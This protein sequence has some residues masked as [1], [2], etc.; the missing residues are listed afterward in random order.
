MCLCVRGWVGGRGLILDEIL[1]TGQQSIFP[2]F[3]S[4]ILSLRVSRGAWIKWLEQCVGTPAT[5]VRSLAGMASKILDVY[6]QCCEH[7]CDK[8][9]RSPFNK[10][11]NFLFFSLSLG[12]D[13]FFHLYFILIFIPRCFLSP[14]SQINPVA[15]TGGLSRTEHAQCGVPYPSDISSSAS[16]ASSGCL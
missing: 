4:N 10:R 5:Q 16:F 12:S 3:K 1:S 9:M 7:S 11:I 13:S 8:S 6:S 2:C 15:I 14:G